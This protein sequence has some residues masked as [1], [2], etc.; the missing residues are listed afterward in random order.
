MI[1]R[2]SIRSE[3]L[4]FGAKEISLRAEDRALGTKYK[5]LGRKTQRNER[6]GYGS[7]DLRVDTSTEITKFY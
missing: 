3:M 6:N 2:N 7:T 1:E 5:A 4:A